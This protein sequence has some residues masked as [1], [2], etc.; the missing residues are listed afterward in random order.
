MTQGKRSTPISTHSKPI[1]TN[2]R[3]APVEQLNPRQGN[4]ALHQQRQPQEGG[5][6][7]NPT[8]SRAASPS[9]N[10]PLRQTSDA[11]SAVQTSSARRQQQQPPFRVNTFVPNQRSVLART[12][13]HSMPSG[14]A[15]GA[16]PSRPQPQQR[17]PSA[18]LAAARA[19]AIAERR[20]AGTQGNQVAW[21]LLISSP[22][23]RVMGGGE[24]ASPALSPTAH[25]HD[26][27]QASLL[28]H[29]GNE[30]DDESEYSPSPGGRLAQREEAAPINSSPSPPRTNSPS[31]QEINSDHPSPAPSS[32]KRGSP[33]LGMLSQDGIGVSNSGR[34]VSAANQ[35]GR[36][37]IFPSTQA[38]DSD[39][40][41]SPPYRVLTE[42]LPPL[43]G[44]RS[45]SRSA[46]F[47]Y[48]PNPI[49]SRPHL[50]RAPLHLR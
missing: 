6:R 25:L 29:Y 47:P 28:H 46:Q 35:G 44:G 32:M 31:R 8:N 5:A 26:D 49:P 19:A 21:E 12:S 16:K 37:G 4:V 13:S 23:G 48:D 30:S 33:G 20:A 41:A 43:T 10:V 11:S 38:W 24:S 18:A 1:N 3:A 36:A 2:R 27:S 14:G 22:G 50:I 7:L 34:F 45:I 42:T 17:A 39:E 15:P 40:V 9:N